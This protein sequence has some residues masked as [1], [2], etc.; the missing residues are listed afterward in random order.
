MLWSFKFADTKLGITLISLINVE[1][2]L[3]E[4][5]K[6]H[7]PQKH[8]PSTKLFFLKLHKIC[9]SQSLAVKATC[10]TQYL[11]YS[12]TKGEDSSCNIPTSP[13][14]EFCNF[15]TP[16]TFIPTSTFIREMRVLRFVVKSLNFLIL[17][18]LAIQHFN[19]TN[20]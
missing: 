18:S 10:F 4:F 15:C 5:E 7:P 11:S 2:T 1:S 6:F 8:P 20:I 16:S 9:L 14:F 19:I 17:A 3:T 13:F 12:N